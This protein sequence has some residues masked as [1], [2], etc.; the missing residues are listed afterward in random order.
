M[1]AF[2]SSFLKYIAGFDYR[3]DEGEAHRFALQW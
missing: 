1:R 2:K 3:L